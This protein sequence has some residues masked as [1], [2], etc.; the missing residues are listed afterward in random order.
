MSSCSQTRSVP[1]LP[2]GPFLKSEVLKLSNAR[3]L[4][5]AVL[6]LV[7]LC[8]WGGWGGT[9]RCRSCTDPVQHLSEQSAGRGREPTVLTAAACGA[10]AHYAS[11]RC[12]ERSSVSSPAARQRPDAH[13]PPTGMDGLRVMQTQRRF[14][15]HHLLLSEIGVRQRVRCLVIDG[16]ARCQRGFLFLVTCSSSSDAADP[17]R[18]AGRQ[19]GQGVLFKNCSGL[20]FVR[21][22]GN[23]SA[24]RCE[25][26]AVKRT[27]WRPFCSSS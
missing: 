2:A 21:T 14:L 17:A 22:A 27:A 24:S 13:R 12:W 10:T 11:I 8:G 16:P 5:D 25:M 7:A 15:Q 9:P 20:S 19:Q 23:K 6:V 26:S 3:A 4:S 1:T 18:L